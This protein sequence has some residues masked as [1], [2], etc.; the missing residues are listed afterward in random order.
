MKLANLLKYALITKG[1]NACFHLNFSDKHIAEEFKDL[2]S[3]NLNNSE[4]G[5]SSNP[6]YY[7]NISS[8]QFDVICGNLHIKPS[9]RKKLI[10]NDSIINIT[11][12]LKQA[13]D[14]NNS[15]QFEAILTKYPTLVE[16]PITVDDFILHYIVSQ[17]NSNLLNLL[18]NKYNV[19]LTKLNQ[20]G[21]S[22]LDIA[23]A[24]KFKEIT[25]LIQTKMDKLSNNKEALHHQ[26]PYDLYA[27]SLGKLPTPALR[28]QYLMD[29]EKTKTAKVENK[30]KQMNPR[31][32]RRLKRRIIKGISNPEKPP[33]IPDQEYINYKKSSI[34]TV[35]YV[36]HQVKIR[37]FW[38]DV[39]SETNKYN[40]TLDDKHNLKKIVVERL[41][42]LGHNNNT[43]QLY[44]DCLKYIKEHSIITVTF[45]ESKT[46]FDSLTDFQLL[47]LWQKNNLGRSAGYKSARNYAE[48]FHF[49]F[50]PD[51]I[52]GQF[53]NDLAVRPRYGSLR[54]L[55]DEALDSL[56]PYG[57]SYIAFKPAAMLLALF[58][59][60]DSYDYYNMS[61]GGTHICCTFNKLE[62][63]LVECSTLF[64]NTI[65]QR[66][67]TG[68]LS[69]G[70][71]NTYKPGIRNLFGYID[72]FEVLLPPINF[73]ARNLVEHIFIRSNK[74]VITPKTI[75]AIQSL[76]INIT[77]S[78]KNPYP[79]LA[80]KFIKY[81]KN[82]EVEKVVTLLNKFPSL[83][84]IVDGN[85]YTPIHIAAKYGCIGV[86]SEFKKRQY[87]FTEYSANEL[88]PMQIAAAF[89]QLKALQTI[90]I[91]I[92]QV[93]KR[94]I[95]SIINKAFNGWTALHLAW[96]NGHFE[97]VD[98]LLDIGANVYA[99]NA[100]G[101][102]FFQLRS[103]KSFFPRN[104]ADNFVKLIR[105]SDDVTKLT[106][107]YKK[108]L[109]VF[110][111]LPL[112]KKGDTALHL[113]IRYNRQ[114]IIKFLV[115]KCR[116]KLNLPNVDGVTPVHMACQ[117]SNTDINLL[118][119]LL[120]NN[121]SVF[122]QIVD[123]VTP[124]EIAAMSGD[125]AKIK[126]ILARL[127]PLQLNSPSPIAILR[128]I[129]KAAYQRG[130]YEIAKQMANFYL[131]IYLIKTPKTEN[132]INYKTFLL[133]SSSS[134]YSNEQKNKAAT[135]LQKYVA[136]EIA[137]SALKKH[138][139]ILAN[140]DELSD[141]YQ[142]IMHEGIN[143]K[144]SQ[145]IIQHNSK[146]K[147]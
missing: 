58:L 32:Q 55:D 72:Y 5:Y 96:E 48:R 107:Y 50:L 137:L 121:A 144:N 78:P 4:C 31:V 123:G 69:N 24:N 8:V 122:T 42:K 27:W 23:K 18:V 95:K 35:E 67:K 36:T 83:A 40:Q 100:A 119:Y 60:G 33:F 39:V 85:G 82:D 1:G 61:G 41:K 25:Q 62:I 7:I 124:L 127:N 28:Q 142:C 34:K 56:I 101:Q 98:Y 110:P 17:N 146:I 30:Q 74:Q 76:G 29:I 111:Y 93:T 125:S 63:L 102:Y 49:N 54:F 13:I 136:N 104:I 84:K 80:D 87:D 37:K 19:D 21:E 112:N 139:D 70:F 52:K 118:A 45:N 16:F 59:V 12:L 53:T 147:K 66:V 57:E 2:I 106:Q 113:A 120:D 44:Y 132:K 130:L 91:T 109:K 115:E 22:A 128:K 131:P 6:S 108:H 99:R 143:E 140:D 3:A 10:I 138:D 117:S 46:D 94:D 129:M 114:L 64:L 15:Q 11:K 79:E 133:F 47:N 92:Q 68:K 126:L 14:T 86:L 81:I 141:I 77:V 71:L 26:Y 88:S 9:D 103:R 73:F 75:K 89:N 116:V 20:T 65:V 38:S 105:T 134:G 135:A 43:E 97:M 90:I 51:N 145:H